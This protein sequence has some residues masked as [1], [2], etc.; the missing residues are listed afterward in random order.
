MF[1]LVRNIHVYVSVNTC[2]KKILKFPAMFLR[3]PAYLSAFA[4]MGIDKHIAKKRQASS[5]FSILQYFLLLL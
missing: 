4:M 3:I 1:V 5:Y 2:R